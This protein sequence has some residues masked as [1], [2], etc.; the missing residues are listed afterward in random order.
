MLSENF[1]AYVSVSYSERHFLKSE[2]DAITATL[3]QFNIE[4]FV[5]ADR[6]SFSRDQEQEMML[7]AMRDLENC[8]VL[9]VEASFKAIGLG[10]EAGYAKAKSKPIVYLRKKGTEHSTTVSGISDFHIIYDDIFDLQSKLS[11][12]IKSLRDRSFKKNG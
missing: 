5:F 11:A 4:P 2:L 7:Q 6:Y 9:I 12:A 1:R 8:D 3:A 10:V